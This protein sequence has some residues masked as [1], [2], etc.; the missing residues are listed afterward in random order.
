MYDYDVHGCLRRVGERW[1][2]LN[3]KARRLLNRSITAVVRYRLRAGQTINLDEIS[4]VVQNRHR[5]FD[6][7]AQN[8]AAFRKAAEEALRRKSQS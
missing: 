2:E 3:Q 5:S 1:S 7:D 6:D 4:K 8:L